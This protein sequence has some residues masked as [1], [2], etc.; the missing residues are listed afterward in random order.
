M[1]NIALAIFSVAVSG[2]GPST[3]NV[4]RYQKASRRGSF[5]G[6]ASRL[7]TFGPGSTNA[8][9]AMSTN[10]GTG[11][12]P[13]NSLGITSIFPSAICQVPSSEMTR[14][15]GSDASFA[16]GVTVPSAASDTSDRRA[17]LK[18]RSIVSF[19]RVSES[20]DRR[21]IP[22][23]NLTATRGVSKIRGNAG[24]ILRKN[25]RL[26]HLPPILPR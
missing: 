18:M 22:S 12:V 5:W 13:G 26:Y 8:G 16:V 9:V 14:R 15:S 1:P 3:V 7:A 19:L 21:G 17:R 10:P 23:V 6:I 24:V 11:T 2:I 20:R 25:P 4:R